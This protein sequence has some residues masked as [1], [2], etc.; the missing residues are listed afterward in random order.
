MTLNKT[1]EFEGRG[2]GGDST[3]IVK[4]HY[5]F[6]DIKL[7]PLFYQLYPFRHSST[8]VQKKLNKLIKDGTK[9]KICESFD[10]NPKITFKDFGMYWVRYTV[11]N[12]FGKTAT[13]SECVS[14]GI[15]MKTIF[16]KAL[17]GIPIMRIF[18][19]LERTLVLSEVVRDLLQ[20]ILEIVL[21][22]LS[23]LYDEVVEY[24]KAKRICIANLMKGLHLLN[25]SGK[26]G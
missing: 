15:P 23:G 5:E 19:A 11:T 1:I 25:I 3:A 22:V 20:K 7:P 13:R 8:L 18:K 4:T 2:E 12:S 14:T 6:S 16:I 10:P 24:F 21:G 26:N 9:T 17:E